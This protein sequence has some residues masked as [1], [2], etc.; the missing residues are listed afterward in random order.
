[1][2]L[3]IKRHRERVGVFPVDCVE[4]HANVGVVHR[5]GKHTNF[6]ILASPD[7]CS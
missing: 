6:E 1:M 2:L 7:G 5:S 3:V 4:V